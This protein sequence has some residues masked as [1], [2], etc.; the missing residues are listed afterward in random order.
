M[1]LL[2]S[3]Y[4][5]NAK[6]GKEAAIKAFVLDYVAR[7][8]G[9]VVEEDDFG[10][11]FFRK[12]AAAPSPCIVAHLDEVHD[13]EGRVVVEEGDM[14]Y[15]TNSAGERVG[16]GADDKNGIWMALRLLEQKHSLRVALFV[17]EE[18]LGDLAGCRGSRACDL[19]RFDDATYLLQCDRKGASDV[20]TVGKGD[21]VLCREGFIPAEL[22]AKYGYC[23]VPGGR[24]DV[25]ALRERGL[26]K[27]C[28]NIGCGYYN[29]HRSDEYT[30]FSHLQNALAFVSEVVDSLLE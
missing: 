28:C 2:K 22:L 29:A 4:R 5:I 14:L 15:A 12:G 6:S 26:E 11:L 13:V 30:L 8:D 25:V 7:I 27:D 17:H 20:V 1:Q 3:L 9:V 16:L 21:V 19:A 18:K 24:T 10:N 23:T